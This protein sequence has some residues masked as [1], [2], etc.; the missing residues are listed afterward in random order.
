MVMPVS[1]QSIPTPTV[2]T[3]SV[4]Y[5]PAS[6]SV[7][8]TNPYTGVST[9]SQVDNSTMELTIKNQPFDYPSNYHLYYDVRF[10][11]H[12]GGNWTDLYPPG[13]LFSNSNYSLSLYVSERPASNSVYTAISYSVIGWPTGATGWPSGGQIDFQVA[14][15]IGINST[16]YSIQ[17]IGGVPVG[18][19]QYKPAI[20]YVS[21]SDWSSTQ[22]VTIPASSVSPSPTP[23]VPELSSSAVILMLIAV[24]F[25]SVMLK[26]RKLPSLQTC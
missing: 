22:T 13:T 2:P 21:S 5:V 23:T 17:T 14:A 26:H 9:T 6:Y 25:A 16:F 8:T 20:A 4:K 19:G 11:P 12:F 24:L 18:S 15:E 10:K 3:L 1:A 7:T